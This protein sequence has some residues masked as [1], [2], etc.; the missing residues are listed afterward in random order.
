M[1]IDNS[2]RRRLSSPKGYTTGTPMHLRKFTPHS[3]FS[4]TLRD[5][6]AGA[7]SVVVFIPH[8]ATETFLRKKMF[9]LYKER[10]L[11]TSKEY[12][13]ALK[14]IVA[15]DSIVKDVVMH[16]AIGK[17]YVFLKKDLEQGLVTVRVGNHFISGISI[18]NQV[19]V[20]TPTAHS[21]PP[22]STSNQL[23]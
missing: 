22:R 16:E 8:P 13:A 1:G 7:D 5:V 2:S 14:D 15:E 18:V 3:Y 11:S 23:L 12:E 21:Q 6:V 4:H 10:M 9:K 17:R 19:A 20:T